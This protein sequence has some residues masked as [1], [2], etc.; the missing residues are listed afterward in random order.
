MQN[1][2][3]NITMLISYVRKRRVKLGIN[4]IDA[5]PLNKFAGIIYNASLQNRMSIYPHYHLSFIK[6]R[7]PLFLLSVLLQHTIGL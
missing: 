6:L 1:I 4:C 3:Y 7:I 5:V 2:Q